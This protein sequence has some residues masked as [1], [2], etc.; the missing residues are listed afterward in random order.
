MKPHY[1]LLIK[2]AV[3]ATQQIEIKSPYSDQT[4]STFDSCDSK[5]LEIAL[6][7]AQKLYEDRKQWLSIEKRIEILEK[8]MQIMRANAENLTIDAASEGGKPY[9]DSR[10]EV[11]R[12]IDGIRICIDCLH[13]HA[14]NMIPMNINS[15][16][17]NRTAFMQYEPI[18]IVVAISAF[19]HPLNLIVHQVAPAIAAGNPVIVK[20]AEDTPVSCYEFINMLYQAG[21][22]QA[23]CQALVVNDINIASA[24]VSDARVA[25][26]SFIGS[27]KIG[28]MLR[29]KL[30]PGTRCSLEHGGVAPVIIE[31]SADID[32]AIPLLVKGGYYHAGQV[33]VSVQRVF[34]NNKSIDTVAKRLQ[35]KIEQLITGDPLDKSTQVGPLIRKQEL[36][37]VEQWVSEAIDQGAELICGG[38]ILDN[39]CYQ[40]TLLLNPPITTKISQQE[41]FGPVVCLYSYDH[42]NSAI[43][44]ANSLEFAFQ[45]AVF[46]QDIDQCMHIAKLLNASAVMI[47]DHTAFRVDWMPFA[48]LKQSGLGTG[49]IPYTFEDMQIA[50]MIV[51]HSTP[52]D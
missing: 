44:Q 34:C 28:W 15:S 12:A 33:C 42:I 24:L 48:G 11:E 50:K 37:R 36:T 1:S 23:W 7:T 29:S 41:V 20:P 43:A 21:L 8:T 45:A 2:G 39:N 13:N 52:I 22:P 5:N 4:I 27:A 35:T 3:P 14:G 40:P 9:I 49:G 26:L 6:N 16:S 38:R 46:S 30:S 47:N 17:N 25:F 10:V 51:L 18:G 19:N 32:K 31:K